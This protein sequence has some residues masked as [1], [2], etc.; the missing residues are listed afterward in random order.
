MRKI[1]ILCV[2][3]LLLV[4]PTVHALSVSELQAQ[5]QSLLTQL[6]SLREQLAQVEK[7]SD[8]EMLV[9]NDDA[10][11]VR[12]PICNRPFTNR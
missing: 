2:L 11:T 7:K 8:T 4:A 1:A 3:G 5:I 12:L 6:A 9:K 10:S